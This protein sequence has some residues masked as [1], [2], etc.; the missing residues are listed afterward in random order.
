MYQRGLAPRRQRRRAAVA[1]TAGS[2]S[3]GCTC[4]SAT[5]TTRSGSCARSTTSWTAPPPTRSARSRRW[6]DAFAPAGRV[7]RRGRARATTGRTGWRPSAA[8]T[9][10]PGAPAPPGGPLSVADV[11][12][13][14]AAAAAGL[15]R[16]ACG[17]DGR[18]PSRP[19][20]VL[21]GLAAIRRGRTERR[22]AGRARRACC[23][24]PR[25]RPWSAPWRG[26]GCSRPRCRA[27][28]RWRR[29][30]LA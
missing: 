16:V 10:E 23:A 14:G 18:R 5:T 29:S 17:A 4:G 21:S 8:T 25:S 26:S 6:R 27:A 28:G 15:L 11:R 20:V 19:A 22:P 1:S 13:A 3:T 7:G 24:R 12:A 9:S 30:S 2:R